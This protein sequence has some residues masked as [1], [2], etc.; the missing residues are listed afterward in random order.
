MGDDVKA[1]QQGTQRCL[2]KQFGYAV[3]SVPMLADS[4]IAGSHL[5]TDPN[6]TAVPNNHL[7]CPC[8]TTV[9][10]D[11][12]SH[13]TDYNSSVT[14][15]ATDSNGSSLLC[16]HV[17]NPIGETPNISSYH[18]IDTNVDQSG[19]KEETEM[20]IECDQRDN[21]KYQMLPAA[22]KVTGLETNTDV[23]EGQSISDSS[24]E[25]FFNIAAETE[26]KEET[27]NNSR[28]ASTQY[29]Q[30][31]NIKHQILP[32]A[33]EE[34]TAKIKTADTSLSEGVQK[35]SQVVA[36]DFHYNVA[37]PQVF[38]ISRKTERRC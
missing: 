33:A 19:Y 38:K 9:T 6:Y 2:P 5:L 25:G 3:A 23:I 1:I 8:G 7:I 37:R 32:V 22:T 29:D 27:V 16:K 26:H 24:T 36:V 28:K 11:Q 14:E 34:K 13:T 10:T 18:S 30:E 12:I 35:E 4:A 21:I 20:A 17:V 31:Y 15:L